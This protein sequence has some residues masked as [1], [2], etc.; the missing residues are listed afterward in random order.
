MPWRRKTDPV[1]RA[2]TRTALLDANPYLW[3]V[4]RSGRKRLLVWVTLAVLTVL[5]SRYSRWLSSSILD[6]GADLLLLVPAGLVLKAW[7]AAEASRTLSED[8]RSGGM[9][10]LLTTPLH[11]RDILRGQMLSLWRQ[12]ALPVAAVLMANLT[13]V[14]VEFRRWGGFFDVRQPL[15]MVHLL[16]GGFLVADM[17]ALSWDGAWLGLTNRKPNRA[18]LLALTRIMVLPG[19]AYIVLRCLWAMVPQ[20]SMEDDSFTGSFALWVLLGLAADLYFGLGARARLRAEF[21]TIVSEGFTR[22][23]PAEAAP[24][25][26]PVLMEAQ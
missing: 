3:R 10:L 16:L 4:A 24:K 8:R 9:E 22:K 26:A 17:I 19:V 11:E 5:W 13:F 2:R 23:R 7:L 21:R 6:P 20:R 1:R 25:P 12:F 18:A 14:L 15:L